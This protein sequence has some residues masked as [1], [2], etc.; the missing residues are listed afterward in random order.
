[1]T[2]GGELTEMMRTEMREF[3]AAQQRPYFKEAVRAFLEKR[4]PDFHRVGA[5]G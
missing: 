1:M 4:D 5:A 3:V 2:H